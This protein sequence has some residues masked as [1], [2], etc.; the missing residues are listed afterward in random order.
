MTKRT[1]LFS[2][3][4]DLLKLI[5]N[6]F[7][8]IQGVYHLENRPGKK[9]T[10]TT[11]TIEQKVWDRD[12]EPATITG[13]AFFIGFNSLEE[14]EAY[15]SKGKFADTIKRARLQVETA[16]EKKLHYQSPTGAIFALKSMGWNEKSDNE[17]SIPAV[18]KIK[19]KIIETGPQPVSNEKDVTL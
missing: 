7:D 5:E 2:K 9:T 14:F 10:D 12:P 4:N 8:H 18:K 19:I 13:L 11:D 16:Y 6:Y 1:T 17:K 3:E 15:E